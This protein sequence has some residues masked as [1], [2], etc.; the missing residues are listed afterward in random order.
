MPKTDESLFLRAA[1]AAKAIDLAQ[2]NEAM[3]ALER[4]ENFD[5]EKFLTGRGFLNEDG[6]KRVR[7]AAAGTEKPLSEDTT[8]SENFKVEKVLGQGGVGRV[9]LAIEKNI[10]REV[11]I[12]ELIGERIGANSERAM[13]RFLREAKISGQLEH[14]N[15]VPVYR[16][17]VRPDGRFYYVM[18][19]VEGRTL[20][21]AINEQAGKRPEK[22]LA[23][24]LGLLGDFIAV[25]EAMGY[26]HSKGIIHRDLKPSNVVIGEFG[27]TIVL[28]WGLAKRLTDPE[29]HDGA[30]EAND[31]SESDTGELRTMAGAKLG[32]P[33]YMAPE[34]VDHSLGT[35]DAKSDVYSLGV[36]LY[37]ILTGEKPYIGKAKEMMER[38]ASA[39][40]SP[41]PRRSDLSIPPELAAICEKAMTKERALRFADASELAAELKAYRDG[42]L[43]GVYAYS[44]KELFRRFISRNK[45][46]VAATLAI[47]LSIAGGFAFATHYAVI[48][49]RERARAENALV[50]ISRLSQEAVELGRNTVAHFNAFFASLVSE[51]RSLAAAAGG[52][53]SQAKITA[54]LTGRSDI[55]AIVVSSDGSLTT[56]PADAVKMFGM[57]PE[58]IARMTID[59]P[60]GRFEA[61]DAWKTSGGRH[62]F[63]L[64]FPSGKNPGDSL[65][66]ILLIEDIFPAALAFDPRKHP[67]QVW[68][69]DTDGTIIYDEDDSEIGRVLFTDESYSNYPELQA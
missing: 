41:S 16:L 60:S 51:L 31:P 34:Q 20:L 69:M 21:H 64:I 47:V 24:R 46:A 55:A 49:E 11:A 67:Y 1:L 59:I 63:A 40:P 30:V 65:T 38:I 6:L 62:A 43:V 23:G 12:K 19:H 26:A 22:A 7:D 45:A 3:E 37:L 4:D 33:P 53:D 25:C 66:A 42:R 27:E 5:A 2:F 35:V 52:I 58:D 61:T 13:A 68:C 36:M 50:D 17:D 14:P 57:P 48:A 29:T 18:R 15:I 44:R 28:D 9:F 8:F 39:E 32:T 10:D 54:F 56:Q